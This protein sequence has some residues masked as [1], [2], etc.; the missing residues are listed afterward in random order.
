MPLVATRSPAFRPQAP[1]LAPKMPEQVRAASLRDEDHVHMMRAK[2]QR[3]LVRDFDSRM[4]LMPGE[5]FKAPAGTAAVVRNAI[6]AR[7]LLRSCETRSALS[8]PRLI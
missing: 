6:R 5:V 8:R 3:R 1:P 4:N 2:G 7:V